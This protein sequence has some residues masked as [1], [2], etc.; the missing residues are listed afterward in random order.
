ML[1]GSRKA[2]SQR[3]FCRAFARRPIDQRTTV[4]E[5]FFYPTHELEQIFGV[6]QP[7]ACPTYIEALNK[8]FGMV[9]QL[10]YDVAKSPAQMALDRHPV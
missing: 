8:L 5:H 4:A 10:C 1:L 2:P 9:S 7:A 6:S 3:I